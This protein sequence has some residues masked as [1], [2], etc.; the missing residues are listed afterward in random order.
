M[1]LMPEDDE[2]QHELIKKK[3]EHVTA[4]RRIVES[5]EKLLASYLR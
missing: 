4:L 2:A 5:Q 3:Q 1:C